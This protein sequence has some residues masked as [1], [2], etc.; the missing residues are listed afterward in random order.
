MSEFIFVCNWQSE[1]V[2]LS[3]AWGYFFFWYCLWS[4]PG[5]FH[6]F[7]EVINVKRQSNQF[8]VSGTLEYFYTI[9]QV[10]V[11]TPN[12]PQL[13]TAQLPSFIWHRVS[14]C[15][16]DLTDSCLGKLKLLI[17]HETVVNSLQFK[18][19]RACSNMKMGKAQTQGQGQD[20]RRD[21]CRGVE[22]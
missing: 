4:I 8:C 2:H 20:N 1:G 18:E 11:Q 22:P 6:I 10:Q 5:W 7:S 19:E 21:L 12:L 15:T 9:C 14:T 13:A 16:H 3:V 17:Y